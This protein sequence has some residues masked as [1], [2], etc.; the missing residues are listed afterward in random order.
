MIPGLGFV[1]DRKMRTAREQPGIVETRTRHVLQIAERRAACS[2]L[3]TARVAHVAPSEETDQP[4]VLGWK[5]RPRQALGHT[6]ADAPRTAAVLT[7]V[8]LAAGRCEG[9]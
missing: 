5:V 8:K 1:V 2:E 9:P 6:I 3:G 4:L 7:H